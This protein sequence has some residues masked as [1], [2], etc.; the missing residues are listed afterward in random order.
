MVMAVMQWT[1]E[2]VV[3]VEE[4]NAVEKARVMKLA[5]E[6]IRGRRRRRWQQQLLAG[7]VAMN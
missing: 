7:N 5:L 4:E 6:G 1:E 3:Q 2:V